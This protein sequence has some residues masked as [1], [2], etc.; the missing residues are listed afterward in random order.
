MNTN[1]SAR[2]PKGFEEVLVFLNRV[3]RSWE[4][5]KSEQPKVSLRWSK[6]GDLIRGKYKP[7]GN[8][9]NCII[10]RKENPNFPIEWEVAIASKQI[11]EG[12]FEPYLWKI[13]FDNYNQAAIF[14]IGKAVWR[15]L[16]K[17]GRVKGDGRNTKQ[18]IFGIEF[19]ALFNRWSLMDLNK[20]D[21]PL[22]IFVKGQT[23]M[24]G[25]K[26]VE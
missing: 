7:N 6:G 20:I 23:E 10:S 12:I 25:V 5:D 14:I 3:Y 21:D 22:E 1:I 16:V 8:E 9:I 17:S 26:D 13:T 11:R 18:N 4:I 15:W 24:L 19:L 2:V